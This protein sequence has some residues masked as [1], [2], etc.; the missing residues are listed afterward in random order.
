[1]SQTIGRMLLV[2]ASAFAM[3]GCSAG[4]AGIL[5]HSDTTLSMPSADH[6]AGSRAIITRLKTKPTTYLHGPTT[7]V[8][9]YPPGGSAVLHRM[10]SSGYVL[11]YVLSGTI[12]AYA[13]HAGVG[14]YRAGDMW[15]EPAFAYNITAKNPSPGESARTLVV[16]VT[17]SQKPDT[18]TTAKE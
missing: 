8:V 9:D 1:M 5:S 17:D 6:L 4:E 11:V 18:T 10:P 16:L 13:W 3:A 2:A 14:T 7:F 15:L 12:R